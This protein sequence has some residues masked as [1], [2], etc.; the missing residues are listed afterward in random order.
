MAQSNDGEFMKFL[1]WLI[2][3][4]ILC[5]PVYADGSQSIV[6]MDEDGR[7]VTVPLILSASSA[8]HPEP[9]RCSARWMRKTELWR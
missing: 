3:L 6:L 8:S 2:I 5:I 7:N 9:P 1:N 4:A